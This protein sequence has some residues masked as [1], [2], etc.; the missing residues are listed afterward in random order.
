MCVG[1][2]GAWTNTT[3]CLLFESAQPLR[4]GWCAWVLLAGRA[5]EYMHGGVARAQPGVTTITLAEEVGSEPARRRV[6]LPVMKE[7][8]ATCPIAAELLVQA[9][10]G[11]MNL[12]APIGVASWIDQ[13][14]SFMSLFLM[15]QP[16]GRSVRLISPHVCRREELQ[17]SCYSVEEC[18]WCRDRDAKNKM[19]P[20]KM[21][22]CKKRRPHHSGREPP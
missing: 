21:P 17:W 8:R 13:K 3:A 10:R 18:L 5:S 19:P 1:A 9:R 15:V 16:K 7:T 11:L 20:C 22:P 6:G 4:I 14:I 2:D 12:L